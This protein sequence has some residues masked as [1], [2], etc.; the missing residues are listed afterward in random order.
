MLSHFI[1]V[2]FLAP[3]PSDSARLRLA[4]EHRSIQQRLER[5]P[6][7]LEARWAVRPADVLHAILDI[8]PQIVHFAGHGMETGEICLQDDNG[9][10]KPVQ[11]EALAA[12]FKL[13]AEYV[14]C[15][16]INTCYSDDQAKAIAEY[17]PIV[18]GMKS[19]IGDRA[20]ITFA[21]GFYIALQA[22]QSMSTQSVEKAYEA[23]RVAIRLEGIQEEQLSPILFGDPRNRLRS[24]VE[25]AGLYT[26]NPVLANIYLTAWI[27]KGTKL[28]LSHDEIEAIIKAVSTSLE[29]FEGKSQKYKQAFEDIIKQEFPPSEESRMALRVLQ[30]ALG[31][32]DEEIARI[33]QRITS[34]PS[35]QSPDT[36]RRRGYTQADQGN[37]QKAIEFFTQ[38]IELQPDSSEAYIGRALSYSDLDDRQAA[39]ANYTQAIEINRD[40]GRYSLAFALNERGYLYH[41]LGD[42]ETAIENYNQALEIKSGS[43][44]T[45]RANVFVNRGLSYYQL[46]NKEAAIE[47][48]TEAINCRP[49]YSLA[50]Y[51]R[52]LAHS[53]LNHAQAAIQD[54]SKAIEINREWGSVVPELCY[55]RRGLLYLE[56]NDIPAGIEDIQKAS[57][58][59]P[60][61]GIDLVTINEEGLMDEFI[62]LVK[63]RLLDR[64]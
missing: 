29:E 48:W 5:T 6:Y 58:I 63:E 19:S 30:N 27:E 35:V 14:Q 37:Y 55:L 57:S 12:L 11:P 50:Y 64:K 49:N 33:E 53:A 36:W 39:I 46:G 31:L 9:H 54:Y 1:K 59:I 24:D 62:D 34:D 16:I 28:G 20:A 45:E 32:R 2:L 38:A 56:L 25:A 4:E 44:V 23:G 61:G 18:I 22:D 42:K 13:A 7:Q 17:V 60:D 41:H 43:L 51:N 8:K 10:V 52:G 15:V 21:T 47:D 40:W 26:R 3:D